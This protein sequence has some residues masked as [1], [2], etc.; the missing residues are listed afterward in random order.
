MS[1]LAARRRQKPRKHDAGA[2]AVSQRTIPD[3]RGSLGAVL[4]LGDTIRNATVLAENSKP[5]EADG[6]KT[7][8]AGR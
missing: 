2:L 6:P 8:Q 7:P 1:R 4:I 3:R 5:K